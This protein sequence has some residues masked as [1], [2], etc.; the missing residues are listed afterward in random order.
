MQGLQ[1]QQMLL[2]EWQPMHGTG[3]L[4]ETQTHP[5][6]FNISQFLTVNWFRIIKSTM[7]IHH[8]PMTLQAAI[9]SPSPGAGIGTSGLA[10][11]RLGWLTGSRTV[12]RHQH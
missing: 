10:S 12:I 11:L 1:A 2:W 6:V 5:S 7:Q 9:C 3:P 4:T 8:M